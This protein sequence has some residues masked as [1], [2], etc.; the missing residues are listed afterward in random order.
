M[1]KKSSKIII[2]NWKM[3]GMLV[4]SMQTIK[5]LRMFLLQNPISCKVV[6]CPPFTLLRDMAEKIPVSSMR[7]PRAAER[8]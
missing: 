3:N 7:L 2:A 4:Q 8:R 6:V 5:Q 1:Q